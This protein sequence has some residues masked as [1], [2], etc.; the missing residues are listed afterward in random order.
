M[1]WK[2]ESLDDALRDVLA[3]LLAEDE[4]AVQSSRGPSSEL[5]GVLIELSLPRARLS[6]TETRGKP[7]SCLGELLWYLTRGNDLDFIKRY[8]PRYERESEDG[9]TVEGGYGTLLFKQRGHDQFQNVFNLLRDHPASRRAVIQLF[10]A[11]DLSRARREVPCT[12]SLQFLIRNGCL[13]MITNMRS[14]DAY[15]GLPHDVFCFTMLQE[16]M[17][18]S[19]GCELGTYRHFVGSLHLYKAHRR[20]AEQFLAEELQPRIEMPEMPVG[21]PRSAVRRVL[22]AELHIRQ[23]QVVDANAY[24]LAPYWADLVRLLQVFDAT[25]NDQRIDTLRSQMIFKRYGVYIDSRRHMKP[26]Q[27]DRPAQPSLL[28]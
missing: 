9:L 12:T 17:A 25:G 5:T 19:L 1:F 26:R 14:N 16:L 18:R 28:V 4:N 2:R 6:R 7:F 23:G 15:M 10:S 13:H 27:P 8:I 24:G 22:Q 11:E 21:D 20:E 3:A